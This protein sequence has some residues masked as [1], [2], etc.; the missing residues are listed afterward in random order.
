MTSAWTKSATNI[1]GMTISAK[2]NRLST[3]SRMK[4]R[5][6]PLSRGSR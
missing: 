2:P 6:G 5:T 1:S 3:K 4:R